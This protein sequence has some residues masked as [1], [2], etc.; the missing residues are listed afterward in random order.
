MPFSITDVF[1]KPL[2][3][4]IFLGATF[5]GA[6]IISF[7]WR[8]RERKFFNSLKRLVR[9]EQDGSSESPL[10]GVN[11]VEAALKALFQARKQEMNR[12]QMLENYRRDYIGNVAHELKTPIFSIQGYLD[13]LIDDP[14]LDK[15]TLKMFLEKAARNTERLVQ[16][17]S[18][19]D[20]ITKYESGF[21]QLDYEDFS[22][23]ELGKEVIE[24]LEIQAAERKINLYEYAGTGDYI[25]H[26][27]KF[28]IRQ[29]LTNL[30]Y[31]SIKYGKE[32]GY[33]KIRLTD[34]GEKVMIEVA[35]NGIGIATEYQGRIFERFFRAEKSRSRDSG[36]SGLGLS[37]C[38]HIVEAHGQKITV[39]STPG[40][41]SVFTFALLKAEKS[42]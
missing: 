21:L 30:L 16:I 33:S 7:L 15:E 3:W 26:A 42:S 13:N 14:E 22:I 8:A 9:A 29:V 27:D 4:W 40:A 12:L 18:D 37:I 17:V 5:A 34:T 28:R 41:G 39:L 10:L 32:G 25:V 11:D 2:F 19:L 36:G 35:D 24:S 6:I 1:A 38:K 23:E 31:N 20:T